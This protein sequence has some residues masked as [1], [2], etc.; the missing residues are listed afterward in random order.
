MKI[1][2]AIKISDNGFVFNS[3]TGDSFSLNP[4]GL[5]LL[6]DLEAG[7]DFDVIKAEMLEQYDIDDLSLEKDF[8]EFFALLKHHQILTQE[9]PLNFQ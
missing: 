6:K 4:M 9:D 3:H 5:Q 8:F 7:K 2:E 1:T